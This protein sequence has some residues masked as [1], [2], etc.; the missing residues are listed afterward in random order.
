M[1]TNW[2]IP[3]DLWLGKTVA[4]ICNGPGMTQA[5]ADNVRGHKTIAV[6]RAVRFALWADMYVALDPEHHAGLEFNGMRVVGVESEEV[7]ALYAGMFYETVTLA[8]GHV[9]QIRNNL[10]A[11]I[12]IAAAAGA[13]KI[14]LVGVDTAAYERTH[15][16]AGLTAGLAA[17]TVELRDRGI[18][19]ESSLEPVRSSWDKPLDE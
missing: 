4:I 1:T 16:F 18:V 2:I 14:I 11:A 12:R 17:L 10:L 7:D 9:I 5:L 3:N 15:E 8:E 19:V 6:H 13:A